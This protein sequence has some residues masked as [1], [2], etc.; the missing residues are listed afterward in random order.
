MDKIKTTLVRGI[1]SPT[2]SDSKLF[3]PSLP[4]SEQGKDYPFGPRR[5]SL[6]DEKLKRIHQRNTLVFRG[7]EKPNLQCAEDALML[8]SEVRFLRRRILLLEELKPLSQVHLGITTSTRDDL[9]FKPLKPMPMTSK[10]WI[11]QFRS[12]LFRNKDSP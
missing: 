11:K 2:T 3:S 10:S 6:D 12:W 5:V 8:V 4:S 7:T 9:K 1:L